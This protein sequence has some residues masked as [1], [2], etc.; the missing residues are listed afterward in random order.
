MSMSFHVAAGILM[1]AGAI[2][3]VALTI[4][5]ITRNFT[6]QTE[7]GK[8]VAWSMSIILSCLSLG[9]IAGIMTD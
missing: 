5:F 2:A 7:G 8:R 1:A 9:I 3:L 6:A 4:F